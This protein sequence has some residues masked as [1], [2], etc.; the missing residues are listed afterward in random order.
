MIYFQKYKRYILILG[1]IIILT[2]FLVL[3][4]RESENTVKTNILS[5]E[6]ETISTTTSSDNT[7]YVDIKGS[8]KKPGVYEFSDGSKVIDAIN[9]AGGLKNDAVTNN[10][11][12]SQRLKDEMV[13]YIFSKKELTTTTIV[14]TTK[15]TSTI[16]STSPKEEPTTTT[17]KNENDSNCKCETIEINNCITTTSKVEN[18]LVNINTADKNDLMNVNGIGESKALAIIEYR[19]TNGLFKNIEDIKSVSGIGDTIFNKIKEYITV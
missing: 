16:I 15:K 11:N 5:F 17:T 4:L 7:I 3:Y 13:I 1:A 10:I 8:I 19:N 18:N 14:T 12:L 2:F 9:K 6:D